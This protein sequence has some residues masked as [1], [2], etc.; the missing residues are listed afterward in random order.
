MGEGFQV[1]NGLERSSPLPKP[2]VRATARR[3]NV[4]VR[5]ATRGPPTGAKKDAQAVGLLEAE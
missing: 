5:A 2:P 4:S 3:T 1:V